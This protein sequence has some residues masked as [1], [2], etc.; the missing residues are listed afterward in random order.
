MFP[1]LKAE[2]S[3]SV[4]SPDIT[5]VRIA[6]PGDASRKAKIRNRSVVFGTA[7][8][9]L[10]R[11]ISVVLNAVS[12]PIVVKALGADGYGLWTTITSISSFLVFADFGLSNGLV[13]IVAEAKGKDDRTSAVRAVS[14]TFFTLLG[15]AILLAALVLVTAPFMRWDTLFNLSHSRMARDANAGI[16]WF[17]L[18]QIASLPALVSQKVQ[19]GYQ[20]M[21]WTNSW[22]IVGSFFSFLGVL[23]SA[24]KGF[25][26]ISFIV[27]FSV[28]PLIAQLIGS[29]VLFSRLHPWL[30]PKVHSFRWEHVRDLSGLGIIFVL[31]Q[32]LAVLGNSSDQIIITRYLGLSAVAE[33]SLAQRLFSGTSL[34]QFFLVPLWPAFGEAVASGD[35][36]WARMALRRTLWISVT[37]CTVVAIAIAVAAPAISHV[38]VPKIR[39]A[40]PLLLVSFVAAAVVGAYGGTMS[41]F[42]N[43]RRTVRAQLG[44]YALA[45]AA[46]V[47]GKFWFVKTV[48]ISGVLWGTFFGYGLFYLYPAWRLAQKTLDSLGPADAVTVND[49]QPR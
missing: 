7:S 24:W 29:Y 30:A 12:I 28:G 47:A 26:L 25:G 5:A 2:A 41:V 46:A 44:I 8:S 23:F 42:L 22:Q 33:Y 40:P 10:A 49:R 17:L 35:H 13:T 14:T 37:L 11:A 16:T 20:E 9:G 39:T 36:A 43:N 6:N 15:L 27:L 19:I 38:W 1:D 45:S 3:E 31:L 21:H 18:L 4:P 32:L 34:I 48:G